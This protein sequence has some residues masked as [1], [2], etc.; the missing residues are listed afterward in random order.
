MTEQEYNSLPGL[1]ATAIK[2]GAVSML[3]MRHCL[4]APDRAD[5]PA[6]R[7]GR[8]VHGAILE[9]DRTL[10]LLRT[11]ESRRAGAA[12]DAFEAEHGAENIVK[13]DEA[14]KL[15]E[16]A[17]RVWANKTARH[18]IEATAHEVTVQ[19]ST[20][21]YGL[22]KARLDGWSLS[23]GGVELKTAR[24][25]SER[26]FQSQFVGLGYDLQLGWYTEGI[27]RSGM[28]TGDIPWRVICVESRPP[29]D[30]AVYRVAGIDLEPGQAKA[31][32]IARRYLECELAGDWPGQFGDGEVEFKLPEWYGLRDNEWTIGTDEED[33]E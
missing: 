10:P 6:L 9:P 18:L 1:R 31:V 15:N 12:W 21:E 7:W 27:V 19:W 11:W 33:G 26:R 29:F 25:I 16:I 14:A 23:A 28:A 5:T 4:T 22:G 32:E 2:A 20:D 30:V 17:R 3:H 8:L 24:D 13:P